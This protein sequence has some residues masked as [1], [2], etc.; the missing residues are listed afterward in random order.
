MALAR[1]LSR[2]PK[3]RTTYLEVEVLTTVIGEHLDKHE[4]L[5]L[6][7][8]RYHKS[9]GPWIPELMEWAPVCESILAGAKNGIISWDR[10]RTA[11]MIILEKKARRDPLLK[12]EGSTI[13]T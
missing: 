4:N 2:R 7:C 11:S 3:A 6:W 9:G 12:T 10:L 13:I 8:G 5:K 1:P